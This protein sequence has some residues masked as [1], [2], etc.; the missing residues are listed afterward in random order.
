LFVPIAFAGAIVAACLSKEVEATD[1][2]DIARPVGLQGS[3]H[4]VVRLS[5]LF[6]LDSFG[7]GFVVQ[8]FIAYWFTEKYGASVGTVGFVFF[9][10]ALLQTGSFLLAPKL[11]QRFGLLNTMVFTHLPSNVLLMCIPLAPN[12][13]GAAALLFARTLLSQMDVP[14][15]QAYVMELVAENERTAAAAYTNTARYVTR[16]LGPILA[17]SVQSIALGAPFVLAGTIKSIYDLTLWRW[18]SRVPLPDPST[19]G[20]AP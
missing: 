10:V 14:S 6:A 17:G 20:V 19:T 5:S 4:S 18:F 15:R 16:P 1:Q 8:A 9:V 12:F 2:K 11:T 13:A 7:G 3:R